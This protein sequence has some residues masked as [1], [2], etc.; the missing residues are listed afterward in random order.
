MPAIPLWMTEGTSHRS[1]GSRGLGLFF[2]PRGTEPYVALL[3]N[4]GRV[5]P[6]VG[7]IDVYYIQKRL[8]TSV[9]VVLALS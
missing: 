4:L 9:G 3:H 7:D 6:D 5:Y 8:K 2:A 1:C